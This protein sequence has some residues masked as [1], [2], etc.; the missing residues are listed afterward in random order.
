[1]NP[2]AKKTFFGVLLM[3]VCSIGSYI[4]IPVYLVPLMLKLQVGAGQV[5][6]IFATSAVGS[7][8]TSLIIGTLVKKFRVKSLIVTGG[9]F[10]GTFFMS[11]SL[12]NHINVIYILAILFGFATVS[13]GF[14]IAQTEIN[15]WFPK[16]T[17]KYIGYLSTAVG[18]GGMLFPVVIANLIESYGLET[19]AMGQGLVVGIAIM[20]LGIFLI[21][22][23][24][25]KYE[26]KSKQQ[27][28]PNVHATNINSFENSTDLTVKQITSMPQFW[29]IVI[30]IILISTAS[31]GFNNNASALYQSK[32][33]T[34]VQ[35]AF[36]ISLMNGVNFIAA[37]LYGM[38]MDKIGYIKATTL[39]GAIV[40][41][42]FFTSIFLTG[43]VG[44]ILIAV[45]M[46]FKTFNSMLGPITL[47][48]LFGARESASL[49]GFTS[50]AQSI[51]AMLGA[52]I[53]GFL[54][55]MT[56][57]YNSFMITGGF[58]TLIT[59][60]LIISGAGTQAVLK[61]AIRKTLIRSQTKSKIS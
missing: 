46:A 17:G 24:P 13:A 6:L 33:S 43:V 18:L 8:I 60:A 26:A 27:D 49:I 40:A 12:S 2:R 10:I 38:L 61:I 56:G 58:L 9:L 54:Y 47:P 20:I 39:Y 59:I 32:G 22:E 4:S 19:V 21:S 29:M 28:Y 44:G 3:T 16:N 45:F 37:P 55:D 42:I 7:L 31:T 34:A 25:D 14:A 51:G 50:A 15:W 11:F 41:S 53:A 57:T 23:Q 48:K 30:A 1:M 5:T 52:P 35:A 36:F